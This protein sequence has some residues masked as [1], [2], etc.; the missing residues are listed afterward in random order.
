MGCDGRRK[1][2]RVALQV[3]SAALSGPADVTGKIA[4]AA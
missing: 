4:E 3:G 2:R 1:L